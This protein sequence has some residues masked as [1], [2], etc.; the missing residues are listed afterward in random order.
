MSEKIQ[1]AGFWGT[2]TC[3]SCSKEFEIATAIDEMFVFSINSGYSLWTGGKTICRPLTVTSGKTHLINIRG[4]FDEVYFVTPLLERI[5]WLAGGY[6]TKHIR[7]GYIMVSIA[8][9]PDN[10]ITTLKGGFR[11]E[12]RPPNQPE[13][14][15]WKKMLLKAKLAI[16]ESPDLTTILA[17]NSVDLYLEELT[18]LEISP[19]RPGSWSNIIKK[20]FGQSLKQILDYEITDVEKFVQIRNAIAHGK[21]HLDRL[22][23]ELKAK[24]EKWLENG[25][26]MEGPGA[27]APSA[28]F[29]L[30][31]A[32]AVIRSCRRLTNN[33]KYIPVFV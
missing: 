31:H 8:P 24:E 19:G 14:K 32:L 2:V 4:V 7:Q 20:H 18:G 22:S 28:A 27:F 30:Q 13:L 10:S 5:Q 16:Y 11:I 33:G 21:N 26:Y 29:S 12:G 6:D 3:H 9:N 17:V 15:P 25:K 1:K 23:G